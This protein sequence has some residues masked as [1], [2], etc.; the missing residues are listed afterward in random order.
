[1][2]GHNKWSQIKYKKGAADAKRSANFTRAG[3]MIALATR[4]GGGDPN[5][6][7]KLKIAIEQARSISMPKENIERAIKRGTGELSGNIIESALYEVYGPAGIGFLIEVAT[8]NKNRTNSEIRIILQKFNAKMASQ[9]SVKFQFSQKGEIIAQYLDSDDEGEIRVI[10]S[11]AMDY[12]TDEEMYF[13][14][15]QPTDLMKV[16]TYL[17]NNGFE[18]KE[19]KLIWEENSPQKIDD[20]DIL[21]KIEKLTDMLEQSDDIIG[22]YHNGIM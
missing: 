11:G 6:N 20:P 19:A 15:T 1:M 18:I 10:D 13:I 22:V 7:F 17:E 5:T 21:A 3:N 8:D 4:E 16:K 9:G 14:T 2:S 12:T